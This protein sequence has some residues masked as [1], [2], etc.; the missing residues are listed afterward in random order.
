V[1]DAIVRDWFDTL[2]A[3]VIANM[4]LAKLSVEQGGERGS[5]L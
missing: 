4:V 3:R 5:R 1:W 2:G